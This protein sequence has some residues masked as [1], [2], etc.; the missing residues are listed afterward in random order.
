MREAL[1]FLRDPAVFTAG[2]GLSLGDF[3][4][5]RVPGYRVYVVTDPALAERVLVGD[6]ARFEKSR[7]YWR[8]LWRVVGDAMGSLDGPRWQSLRQLQQPFFTPRAVRGYLPAAEQ[9]ATA[10][11]DRL[12]ESLDAARPV[13][14]PPFLAELST[15][16]LLATIFG[17]EP[18]RGSA[19][20]GDRIADGEA[21]IAWRSKYP[22]RPLTAWLT[23]ANQRAGRH[24]RFF[25]GFAEGVRRSPAASDPAALVHA[26][27]RVD[28]EE[29]TP[30]FPR[31]L[32]RNEIIVHL[33]AGTETQA[34]AL[35]WTLYLLWKHPDALDRI[36]REAEAVTGGARAGTEHVH[37]LAYVTRVVRE[38]LRLYPPSY[39]LV[40]ECIEPGVLGGERLR[41]GDVVFISL[42]GLHR[43][44]RFWADADRFDPDRFDP[45]RAGAIGKYQYMPFGAGG[46][47]CIGQHLA[48]PCIVLTVA[49]FAQRFDWTFPHPHVRPVGLATLKPAGGL[50]ATVA[51]RN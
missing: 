3:Y 7:I 48:L 18:D 45:E 40:R 44:P 16:I 32:L 12:A 39:A 8:E 33:G 37:R 9:I 10:H 26:L 47:A 5:V 36:R 13:S 43:S 25:D 14:L 38:A 49:Q 15:R 22:W 46:H 17:Q 27:L 6:A 31:S 2:A 19:E 1:A 34:V 21:T 29:V 23:G 11:L 24:R 35:G 4:R 42:C 30:R 41:R 28:A 50:H 51:R 20:I